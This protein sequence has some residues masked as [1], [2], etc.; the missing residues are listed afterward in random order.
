A[1]LDLH[2]LFFLEGAAD[3]L[4]LLHGERITLHLPLVAAQ[5]VLEEGDRVFLRQR[6]HPRVVGQLVALVRDEM[7]RRRRGFGVFRRCG[8]Q[9]EGRRQQDEGKPKEKAL[10]AKPPAT[11]WKRRETIRGEVSDKV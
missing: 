8:L 7:K 2:D 4:L 1:E 10:H 11:P 3:P 6:F 5:A 9:Q